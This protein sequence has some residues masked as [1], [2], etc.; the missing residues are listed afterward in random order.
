MSDLINKSFF[1]HMTCFIWNT[2][3]CMTHIWKVIFTWE[4]VCFVYNINCY[5]VLF[6]CFRI[7]NFWTGTFSRHQD[8][9]KR[10]VVVHIFWFLE[11][12]LCVVMEASKVLVLLNLLFAVFANV[13][14][15]CL[16]IMRI[17][18]ATTKILFTK[19][20]L[21]SAYREY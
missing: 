6:F 16:L 7:S 20:I 15:E 9:W 4:T 10:F 5:Y 14:D 8:I 13:Y 12:L 1:S 11:I 19:V 21:Q 2:V 17:V 18:K 3:V